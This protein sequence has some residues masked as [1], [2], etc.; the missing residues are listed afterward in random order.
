MKVVVL[1]S[2]GLLGA[3]TVREWRAAGHS[4]T[5]LTR[6]GLDVT[7]D[8]AV[9]DVIPRLAPDVVINCAAYNLV[10]EAELRPVD[11]LRVNAFAVRSLARAASEAGATLVHYSTDFVFD[12]EADRPYTEEAEPNPMSAYGLSKLLGEWFAVD[13]PRHYVLRVESLFGGAGARSSV[14]RMLDMMRDGQPVTAF[15]DRTVSPSFIHDVAWATRQLVERGAAFGLYHCVNSGQTTW[16]G[17]AEALRDSLGRPE[18]A[19]AASSAAAT[20][21]PAARPLFAALSNAKL[22]SVGIPMPAWQDALSRHVR[23]RM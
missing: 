3:Q 20:V 14:D 6:A 11:A 19:I 17:L 12:G 4:V 22:T 8:H 23:S 2:A 15:A 7:S 9:R 10:D 13:T 5:A 16:L 18:A 1:G 21:L